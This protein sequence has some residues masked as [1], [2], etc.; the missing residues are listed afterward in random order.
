MQ[1]A[2]SR[3]ICR[4]VLCRT[5]R[6]VETRGSG[7]SRQTARAP[8][9]SIAGPESDNCGVG[10]C[11]TR[12]QAAERVRGATA[13][14]GRVCY[15]MVRS[16][17]AILVLGA[18]ESQRRRQMT[19]CPGLERRRR[20]RAAEG[21][22]LQQRRQ[23]TGIGCFCRRACLVSRVQ[24]ALKWPSLPLLCSALCHPKSCSAL[25]CSVLLSH[26]THTATHTSGHDTT[27]YI[28]R[29]HHAHRRQWHA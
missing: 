1:Q 26:F 8:P 20:Q 15:T 22:A 17:V 4:Q 16:G 13:I 7:N 2:A 6:S 3:G 29:T 12:R 18:S 11:S 21:S 9:G 5:E 23:G 14:E 24:T 28:L 27:R 25:L 19:D 10:A